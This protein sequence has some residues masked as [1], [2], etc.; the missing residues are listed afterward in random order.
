MRGGHVHQHQGQIA[1]D[2]RQQIVE[3]V[4]DAAGQGLDGARFVRQNRNCLVLSALA[5]A[6]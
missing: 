2:D 1:G 4:R 6:A 5:S 3:L